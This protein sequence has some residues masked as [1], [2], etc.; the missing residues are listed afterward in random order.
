MDLT[1]EDTN[2][3]DRWNFRNADWHLYQELCSLLPE[4]DLNQNI[5]DIVSTFTNHILQYAAQSIPKIN[6]SQKKHVPW[7]SEDCS[8][9]IQNRRKALKALKK[10][11]NHKN[12]LNYR[13]LKGVA[14]HT[15]KQAKR[16]SWRKN[17]SN[18][19][20]TVSSAQIW[21]AIRKI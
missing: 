2:P 15:I 7:W 8:T 17:I 6:Y 10:S 20:S 11:P 18:I 4:I 3:P 5:D 1:P 14:Q 19:N 9:V 21:S 13:R 12:L 16:E